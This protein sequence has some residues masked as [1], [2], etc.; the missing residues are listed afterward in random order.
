MKASPALTAD[1]LPTLDLSNP[2]DVASLTLSPAPGEEWI[3]PGV[4]VEK[5]AT[6]LK[7]SPSYSGI[8]A[9][10]KARVPIVKFEAS[11]PSYH[12]ELDI[13]IN[14]LLALENSEL[15]KAYMG[16]DMRARQLTFLIKHWA[17]QRKI[18]DPFR[19]T[20]SSYAYVL[21]TIHFL[22]QLSP[23]VL[24]CLQ[25]YASPNRPVKLVSGYDCH[26]FPVGPWVSHNR[27]TLSQ[28]W[29]GWL[30]Y[31]AHCFG[32]SDDVVSVRVGEC[33]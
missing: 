10:P 25:T 30:F 20:L 32:Y 13:G 27:C 23:P 8:L 9:L 4:V 5:L 11:H 14:N 22:Q 21:M 3:E 29:S 12:Y 2:A 17:K 6:L 1:S 16:C 15:I 31:F 24:P 19:G 18:N 7:T 26:F 28:L 33:L